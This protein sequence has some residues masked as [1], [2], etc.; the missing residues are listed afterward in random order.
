MRSS[1]FLSAVL[2]CS[3][4]FSISEAQV[5]TKEPF[6]PGYQPP[7][8]TIST[9]SE[10]STYVPMD[11]WIYPA[12]DRLHSLGYLDTAFMGIRPWTRLSIAHMLELSADRIDTDTNNDEARGIYLA[13]LA[14]VQ[15]DIDNATQLNHP[16]AQLE[17]VYTQLRGISGTPLRDS[18]HLG[19]TIVDDYGRP[20]EGGFN[21]YTGFS[22]R[23]EAGRFSLYWRGEYEYAPSATGYSAALYDNLSCNIDAIYINPITGGPC[24]PTPNQDT[25]PGGPIA[26][27]NNARVME[28][29]LS[30]HLLGHEVSFGR[31]DNGWDR[32]RVRRC[33]GAPTP[34][35]FITFRSIARSRCAFRDCRERQVRF[36]TNSLSAA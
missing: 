9:S 24:T 33:C 23:A 4:A 10:G 25:I 7:A 36:A 28:A 1:L 14:E 32:T 18:F 22:G 35:T 17:S 34:R 5:T 20:Y 31:S 15:P 8:E 16:N 26:A 27:A 19:Q 21:S 6:P 3:A 13:V 12:L 11:S 30:Y 29:N 2:L